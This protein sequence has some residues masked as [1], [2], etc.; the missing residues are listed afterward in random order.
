LPVI[1]VEFTVALVSVASSV[2]SLSSS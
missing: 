2:T 1:V